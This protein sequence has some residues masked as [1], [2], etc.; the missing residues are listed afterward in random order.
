MVKPQGLIRA[1][2]PEDDVDYNHNV[3]DN[4]DNDDYDV[5]NI[6]TDSYDPVD[7]DSTKSYPDFII[8]QFSAEWD[9]DTL[10]VII[11]VKPP[12]RP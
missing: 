4:P 10:K 11:E 9:E 5:G 2:P 3:D 1:S 7:G 12:G 8:C 6:T